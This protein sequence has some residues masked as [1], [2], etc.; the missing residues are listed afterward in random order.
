MNTFAIS[1]VALLGVLTLITGCTSGHKDHGGS[2]DHH[3]SAETDSGHGHEA[4]GEDHHE[5]DIGMPG[6]A[7]SVDRIIKV[8]MDD[9]M[10]FT[11]SEFEV[12]AGETIQFDVINNG[13]IAHEFVLGTASEIMEHHE[14]MQKFPGMEHDEPNSVSLETT[15]EGAVIWKFTKAGTVDTACLKAGHFEAG[16]KGSVAVAEK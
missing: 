2:E 1:T 8:S 3:A 10:R 15:A 9:T 11:P 6:E 7:S 12:V 14:L 13:K 4:G 16:M 5:S